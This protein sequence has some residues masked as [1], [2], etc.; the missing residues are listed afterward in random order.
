[1]GITPSRRFTPCRRK[2]RVSRRRL[3]KDIFELRNNNFSFSTDNDDSH[4]IR[5]LIP[6]RY[7]V[8]LTEQMTE[9][10]FR[11]MVFNDTAS[12]T[13]ES[14]PDYR[15][16]LRYSI[17]SDDLCS[18]ILRTSSKAVSRR[19]SSQFQSIHQPCRKCQMKMLTLEEFREL[20]DAFYRVDNDHDNYLT[21]DEI[22]TTL[23]Y[24][25]ELTEG[26][27]KEIISVFDTNKD[28]RISLEEYIGRR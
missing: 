24:L 21:K 1:M 18:P 15:A 2:S 17:N 4:F 23:N 20:H 12:I 16:T 11:L 10:L 5:E 28:D 14:V 7:L 19:S 25:F 6:E 8:L 13:S 3:E 22:R 26:D 27:I 9:M